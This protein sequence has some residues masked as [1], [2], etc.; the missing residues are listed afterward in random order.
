MGQL[1]KVTSLENRYT[2]ISKTLMER[3]DPVMKGV[4]DIF[5]KEYPNNL[6]LIYDL[7]EPI[8]ASTGYPPYNVIYGEKPG[9]Y[10]VEVALAGFSKDDVEVFVKDEKLTIRSKKKESKESDTTNKPE[11]L[12]KGIGLRSFTLSFTLPQ[13][14]V[15]ESCEMKDGLLRIEIAKNI[16]EDQKP[17]LIEIK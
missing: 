9:D 8:S 3:F 7:L 5:A 14:S 1:Q 16:P 4:W 10:T 15:I 13:N 11:Y 6:R 2:T 12:K 17:K